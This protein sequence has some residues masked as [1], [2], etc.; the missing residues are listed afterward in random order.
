MC[1]RKTGVC[2]HTSFKL[3]RVHDAWVTVYDPAALAGR[4]MHCYTLTECS[5]M[6]ANAMSCRH[7]R[8]ILGLCQM[9]LLRLLQQ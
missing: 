9:Q 8:M 2:V 6:A 4:C 1:V 7:H 5:V 3:K